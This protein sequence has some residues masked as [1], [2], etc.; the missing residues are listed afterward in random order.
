MIEVIN[1]VYIDILLLLFNAYDSSTL[2]NRLFLFKFC[3]PNPAVNFSKEFS[4][5]S[6]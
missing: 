2:F 1:L 6:L 4:S 3:F 5:F